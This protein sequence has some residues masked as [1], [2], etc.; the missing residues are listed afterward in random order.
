MLIITPLTHSKL[1]GALLRQ[2]EILPDR[3]AA[4][5]G[6]ANLQAGGAPSAV[7]VPLGSHPSFPG[8]FAD[9]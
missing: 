8:L 3:L 2:K 6:E 7:P 4:G 5:M 1:T 9:V